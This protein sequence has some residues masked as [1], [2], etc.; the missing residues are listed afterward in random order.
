MAWFLCR[1]KETRA[2]HINDRNIPDK[3]D[4]E[5]EGKE[6]NQTSK[7]KESSQPASKLP[8]NDPDGNTNR[9]DSNE[10]NTDVSRR[11]IDKEMGTQLDN[12]LG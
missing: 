9:G 2:M 8:P 11:G 10:F 1:F 4:N 3:K 5:R 6:P 7:S 12:M